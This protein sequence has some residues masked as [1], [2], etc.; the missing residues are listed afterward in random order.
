MSSFSHLSA[1]SHYSLLDGII[2]IDALVSSA[3]FFGMP[4]LALTDHN[5]LYGAIEFY[6]AC[7]Q[8]GIKPILGVD[9][10]ILIGDTEDRIIFLAENNEGYQHLLKLV[11]HAYLDLPKEQTG[12]TLPKVTGEHIQKYGKGLIALI[13]DTALVRRNSEALV[14]T[15]RYGLGKENVYARL[16]WNGGRDQQIRIAGI[17][18]ALALPTVASDDSYYLKSEDR[19]ARDIVRRIATPGI[20]PDIRDL[21]FC[22]IENAQEHYSDFPEALANAEKIAERATVELNLGSWL[23][24][25]FP[26]PKETTYESELKVAIAKGLIERNMEA[27]E[28]VTKRIDYELSIITAK[29][30]APYFLTVADLLSHARTSGILTTTRG[31]AAGSLVSYLTGITNVDPITYRLPFERFLNPERPS[32]PDIDMDFADNRRDEMLVY[33]K[34][35]YGEECVAQIGTFGTMMARAAVRDVARAL[36]YPYGVGDRIAKLIP[37]GSQGFPMTLKKALEMEDELKKLYKSDEDAEIIINTAKQVEG[38]ARHISIH[39]AGIVIAPSAVSDFVPVQFEPSGSAIITQYDMHEVE[40]AGLLKFDFLGLTNLSILGDSVE[41]VKVRKD[42]VVDIENI[43]LDDA[44]TFA[45][46]A[47]GE[48]GGVFQLGGSGMTHYLKDLKPTSIHDINAMVALYRPG[49]MESIPQYIERKHNP[50]LVTYLDPRMKEILDRS[51]GII[52]YQDDVLLIAIH[53]A[54]YTWLEADQL[55]KA[56]GKKIPIEMEAQKEKFIQGCVEKGKIQKTKAESLWKLIEPFAAYG[57]NKGHAASYGK[58]A[59]QTAYMKANHPEDYMASLLTADSGDTERIADDV[60]ECERIGIRVL[61]PD[62]NESY[63]SF[64]VIAHGMIRFGLSTIKNFGEGAAKTI[65]EERARGGKFTSIG[66]VLSRVPGSII[67]RR[68]LESLIKCG[69]FDA[70]N[71]RGILLANI[72]KLL[73]FAKDAGA[74]S[75]GQDSLFGTMVRHTE[76]ALEPAQPLSQIEM[77]NSEKELLGIYVS[78]H[79]L[80]QFKKE[81]ADYPHSI[82]FARG[83]ER[84]GYPLTVCGVIESIKTILTKKGDKMAFITISDKDGFIET[85]AFPEVYKT[86]ASVMTEGTCVLFKGKLSKRNGE[87][88]VLIDKVKALS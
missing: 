19:Q 33:A 63:E 13:P 45:M 88:S 87:P 18:T 54:G 77:L 47:R 29:G 60:A 53:L 23:F 12:E 57:F 14:E 39:A 25:R 37:L 65:I 68:A 79:P 10:D 28:E 69:V 49:P 15:L 67:N 84:N 34:E 24:P 61:P 20:A 50:A 71:N 7:K 62:I 46:L 76:I 73:L 86:N 22:S 85:V 16:G 8:A 78:G 35:K 74:T 3:M 6:K 9:A 41:R 83:E 38:N 44:K 66:D 30:F 58:V 4:A 75:A 82:K 40:D 32:A 36:G 55:R 21:T 70:F 59:Y 11:S 64:T 81:L 17:A 27:T 56:M 52:T 26:I 42:V 48:T 43:P 1:H 31:S 2:Q 80:D 72:E 5:N 51:Y